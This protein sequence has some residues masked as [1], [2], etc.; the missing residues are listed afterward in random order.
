MQEKREPTVGVGKKQYGIKEFFYDLINDRAAANE[1]LIGIIVGVAF[2]LAAYFI[3]R[4]ELLFSTFPLVIAL[5]CAAERHI[6]FILTGLCF[7]AAATGLSPAVC[8]CT[9]CVT[10]V[11]RIFSRLAIDSARKP[12][13]TTDRYSVGLQALIKKYRALFEES[14]Y[15][16]MAS[17]ALAAFCLSVYSV[18]VGGFRYYDLFGACFSIVT[19]PV[20]T[21]MFSSAFDKKLK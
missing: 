21:F 7:S 5:L 20:A 9:Y 2:G 16:R 1:R 12:K 17:A 6:P 13:E 4:C 15:L 18:I 3:G 14:V 11:I 8:I 19:A 10:V